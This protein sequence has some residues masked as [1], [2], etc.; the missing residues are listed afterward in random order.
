MIDNFITD[1]YMPVYLTHSKY[2]KE[3]KMIQK[4]IND[5]AS[6]KKIGENRVFV[7]EMIAYELS[8]SKQIVIEVLSVFAV[9][10]NTGIRLEKV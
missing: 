2:N 6:T 1:R 8:I 4:Y 9:A 3:A 7:Y 10:G 5:I